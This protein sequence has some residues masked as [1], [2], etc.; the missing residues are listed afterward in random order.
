[1]MDTIV[2][3]GQYLLT[4]GRVVV[5]EAAAGAGHGLASDFDRF[6]VIYPGLDPDV[7]HYALRADFVR[8]VPDTALSSPDGLERLLDL[9]ELAGTVEAPAERR[10][11]ARPAMPWNRG[12][13]NPFGWPDDPEVTEDATTTYRLGSPAFDDSPEARSIYATLLAATVGTVD[14]HVSHA[15]EADNDDDVIGLL[16]L[17]ESHMLQAL[18]RCRQARAIIDN[19]PEVGS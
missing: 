6:R 16:E 13:A 8:A 1:M 3:G 10:R 18:E 14:R 11:R 9:D 4:G 5:V 15:R 17:A 12:A 19:T 7:A 2:I